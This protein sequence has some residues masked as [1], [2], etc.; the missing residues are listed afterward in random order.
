MS[1][2][3]EDDL[4]DWQAGDWAGLDVGDVLSVKG[5][6]KWDEPWTRADPGAVAFVIFYILRYGALLAV[7]A[8]V[9]HTKR[10]W[11]NRFGEQ[12]HWVLRFLYDIGLS[13]MGV[14]WGDMQLVYHGW[15]KAGLAKRSG[16]KAYVDN[17]FEN[18]YHIGMQCPNCA[19]IQYNNNGVD[20]G[21]FTFDAAHQQL[22]NFPE[23][24]DRV[25]TVS[26]WWQMANLF[27]L[28]VSQQ[29]WETVVKATPP[30]HP[31]SMSVFWMVDQKLGCG[32]V[33]KRPPFTPPGLL[34]DRPGPSSSEDSRGIYAT[35]NDD[36]VHNADQIPP[37]PSSVGGDEDNEPVDQQRPPVPSSSSGYP[38]APHALTRPAPSSSHQ[39]SMAAPHPQPS[40]GVALPSP[41]FPP[42][43]PGSMAQPQEAQSALLHTLVNSRR[44]GTL[45]V[46]PDGTT[47]VTFEGCER[48]A[49]TR[50]QLTGGK[51]NGQWMSNKRQRA[52]AHHRRLQ[53]LEARGVSLPPPS[54]SFL[55]CTLCGGGQAGQDCTNQCC[56]PCC[57]ANYAW[58]SQHGL[59]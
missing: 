39:W 9:N 54:N 12:W 45:T 26:S 32:L 27:K 14:A 22:P 49:A 55:M 53:D 19:L 1:E 58:C 33:P 29:L 24:A 47:S 2:S 28:P 38:V 43:P 20:T 52:A 40:Q 48:P 7:C 46:S 13:D 57:F 4:L 35:V 51:G 25:I 5:G 15:Q 42:A 36:D 30:Y 37:M 16:L 59:T 34:I 23:V 11:F 31:W 6:D 56:S 10:C 17:N 50:W 3:F 21:E 8:R 44:G 41:D 18:L